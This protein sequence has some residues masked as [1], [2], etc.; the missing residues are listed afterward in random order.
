MAAEV[1]V[2]NKVTAE[3]IFV[4]MDEALLLSLYSLYAAELSGQ[5]EPQINH[6]SRLGYARFGVRA[7]ICPRSGVCSRA[8][9]GRSSYRYVNLR[10]PNLPKKSPHD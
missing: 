1:G 8:R 4:Q 9:N 2:I 5:I 6:L 10:F 3:S 7:G